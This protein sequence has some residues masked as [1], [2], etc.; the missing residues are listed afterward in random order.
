MAY[1]RGCLLRNPSANKEYP[2]IYL[3]Y[4]KR[5]PLR[6]EIVDTADY[7]E[8]RYTLG[9]VIYVCSM[10]HNLLRASLLI[11][12]FILFGSFPS[13]PKIYSHIYLPQKRICRQV[14][15]LQRF[16]F[17]SNAPS[18]HTVHHFTRL[19]ALYDRANL[20]KVYIR[21]PCM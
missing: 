2:R 16:G 10:I 18:L 5:Q 13:L 4:T 21:K 1:R 8:W 9:H 20:I 19:Q 12:F 7:Q 14:P 15:E 11:G 6:R 17:Y 3:C